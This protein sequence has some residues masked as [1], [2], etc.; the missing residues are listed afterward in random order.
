[1]EPE[2]SSPC[3]QQPAPRHYTQP[4]ELSPVHQYFSRKTAF[5][6][7]LPSTSGFSKFPRSFRIPHQNSA[8]ISILQ[9]NKH[10]LLITGRS[11]YVFRKLWLDKTQS[12][13]VIAISCYSPYG[14]H[15]Q[16]T[17]SLRFGVRGSC[18]SDDTIAPGRGGGTTE[19][20]QLSTETDCPWQG[21]P[22]AGVS[23]DLPC[24]GHVIRILWS[25]LLASAASFK[26]GLDHQRVCCV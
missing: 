8:R 26:S 2:C 21:S 25:W 11:N 23:Y 13:H 24:T 3:P 9:C 19:L 5:D 7:T 10:N 12:F 4:G 16:P 17:W 14:W 15:S 20:C 22:V 18:L 1:M 6:I